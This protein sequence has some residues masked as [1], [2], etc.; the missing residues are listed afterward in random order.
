[1]VEQTVVGFLGLGRMGSR[2]AANIARA[3]FPLVVY[4]R[5]RAVADGFAAQHGARVAGTPGEVAGSAEFVISMLADGEALLD[6]Y[7]SSD[8]V[9]RSLRRGSLAIDMGTSGMEAVTRLRAEVEGIES[10]FV[11]A[12]VSGSIAAAEAGKLPVMVGAGEEE[13][14][15][16]RPILEAV[17]P[18]RRVGPPG[19]AALLKLTVNSILYG[20]NQAV[21]EGVILAEAGGISPEV[22][23][24]VIVGSAAGA[25]MVG[26]RTPQ[27][28]VPDEAPIS[29]TLDLVRKDILLTLS[30]AAETGVS[31]PQLEATLETIDE[32]I[33]RGHGERD[34]GYVIE[35]ERQK[36]RR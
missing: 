16:A 21:A 25:P 15:R 32:L 33:S 14:E 36:R 10:S 2:M 26:Y 17:G 1:V 8:G 27:Y 20:L 28:L 30:Q 4:N 5:T 9:L 23:L 24:D 12:P 11:D 13:F 31:M 3:G 18:V 6:L 29:F 35:G 19:T 34:M 22:T 7:T